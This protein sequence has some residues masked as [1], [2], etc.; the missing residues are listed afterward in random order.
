MNAGRPVAASPRGARR[1]TRASLLLAMAAAGGCI[2]D[3][4]QTLNEAAERRALEDKVAAL[5]RDVASRDAM[6]ADQ[7]ARIRELQR[8]DP[9]TAAFIPHAERIEIEAM[10]GTYDDNRDG[11]PDGIVVYLRA[12]DADGDVV[13]AGGTITVQG[14]DL[15]NPPESQVVAECALDAE[16]VRKAWYGK[17]LTAHYT[18]KCPWKSGPPTHPDLTLRVRFIDL[19]TGRPLEAVRQVK[20]VGIRDGAGAPTRPD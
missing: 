1:R 13:K 17:F 3:N 8:I 20:V 5:Q 16:A 2:P 18:I 9:R 19:V 15:Q 4:R 6:I 14:L 12:L 10:S 7:A 11:R